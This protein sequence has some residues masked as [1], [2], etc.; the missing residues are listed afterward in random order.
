MNSEETKERRGEIYRLHLVGLSE[1][2]IAKSLHIDKAAVSR[3]ITAMRAQGSW[4][5]RNHRQLYTDIMQES[6]DAARLSMSQAWKMYNDAK[7]PGDKMVALGRVQAGIK[8]VLEIRPDLEAL[9][10][11]ETLDFVKSRQDE[12]LAMSDRVQQLEREREMRNRV[13]PVSLNNP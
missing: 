7:S 12:A 9:W 11:Q 4:T 2:E 13:L 8:L 1:D 5:G 6:Y 3:H 10:M